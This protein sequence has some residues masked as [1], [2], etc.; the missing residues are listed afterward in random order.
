M[1]GEIDE[2]IKEGRAFYHRA[3]AMQSPHALGQAKKFLGS[4]EKDGYS[5]APAVQG[6][7]EELQLAGTIY[8]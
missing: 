2:C 5:N 7:Q 8:N 6:F 1:L 3:I 4:L